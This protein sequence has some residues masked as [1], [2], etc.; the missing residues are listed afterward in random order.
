[1]PDHSSNWFNKV[2]RQNSHVFVIAEIGVNHDGSVARAIE[3]VRIAAA[4]GA[5]AVKLQLFRADRLMHSSSAF[6]AYQQERVS[7]ATPAEMLRRYE[8]SEADARTVVEEIRRLGLAPIATPFSPA[9]LQLIEEFDLP[10]IKIASPDLVNWPLLR[11]AARLHKPLLVS[12]G[13]ATM[14]E[15][16]QTVRWLDEWEAPAALLHCVSSY[17]TPDDQAHLSWIREL[18]QQFGLPTGYSD[19]TTEPLA[20]ALAV[21]AGAVI[22]EKHLTYDRCAHGPDHSASSDP[23]QFG[24]YV[25]MIR[26]AERLRG[27]AGK[28]VLAAEE[29]VRHVSRQS[30]VLARNVPAGA[31]LCEADFTVQRPGSGVPAAML[32]AL[33]GRRT[34]RPLRAGEM[35]KKDMLA[36][37]A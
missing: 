16:A 2:T 35:L 11:G 7:D 23:Q 15:V 13:A 22:I 12:T 4:C 24:E 26:T 29:D 31:A 33:L 18:R 34:A 8:L 9:D 32:P 21:S 25:R 1:M 27:T 30:L 37:A 36:H 20:G 28:R 19:H 5:D 3:L 10:A 17:P 14:D 6:A